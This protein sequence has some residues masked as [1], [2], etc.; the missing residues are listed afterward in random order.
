MNAD[1]IEIQKN[2]Y[3]KIVLAVKEFK[4]KKYIDLR[5]WMRE[6]P[7]EEWKPT[8]KGVTVPL[9]KAGELRKAIDR[10]FAE[11]EFQETG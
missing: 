3:Q 4:D 10:L 9:V 1:P 2:D 11:N 8:K 5:T 7:R 6:D